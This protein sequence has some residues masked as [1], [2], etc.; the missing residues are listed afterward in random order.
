ML[1]PDDQ[2]RPMRE[3]GTMGVQ[4]VRRPVQRDRGLTGPGT[5]L[6]DEDAVMP[7]PDDPVL[8][9]LDRLD[10]V[11][12]LPGPTR[13]HRRQQRVLVGEHVVRIGIDGVEIERLVLDPEHLASVRLDMPAPRQPFRRCDGRE[14]KRP[15]RRCPPIHQIGHV[16]IGLVRM[17]ADAADIERHSFDKV[18]STETQTILDRVVLRDL[19]EIQRE[20][21]VA[22]AAGLHGPTG[23]AALLTAL[24]RGVQAI[25]RSLPHAVEAPVQH[26]NVG[27]LASDFT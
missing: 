2:H 5:A 20:C 1:G 19:I 3:F 13:V 21:A 6:H 23:G 10:D 11:A 4:Q 24:H 16:V 14:I 18:Q 22:L 7:G 17:D 8:L 25:L 9:D 12:H 15:R 26:G 27:L